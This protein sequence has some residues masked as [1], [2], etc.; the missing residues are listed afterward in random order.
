MT[1]RRGFNRLFVVAFVCWNLANLG[2]VFKK[3]REAAALMNED[4]RGAWQYCM[5][6][7]ECPASAP[8][9]P[10]TAK[11]SAPPKKAQAQETAS[12]G[13]IFPPGELVFGVCA[14]PFPKNVDCDTFEK[15]VSTSV[16][17]EFKSRL[18]DTRTLLYIEGIPAAVYTLCWVVAATFLWIARG[19][20]VA[21]GREKRGGTK[22]T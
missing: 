17:R 8:G 18:F 22:L 7:R 15:M 10:D 21:A 12:G 1:I 13:H 5:S 14:D 20:G 2:I 4:A 9:M 11:A 3:A 6:S 19:F 16:W